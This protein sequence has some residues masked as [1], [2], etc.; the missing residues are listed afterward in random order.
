MRDSIFVV[1][2]LFGR[3]IRL[4]EER[5]IHILQRSELE[6]QLGK[7]EQTL[8]DP[9]VV[10]RSN[11]DPEIFLYYRWYGRTPVGS[12]YLVCIAKLENHHGFVL[13]SFF[14]DKVKVGETIWQR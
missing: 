7:I 9:D 10:K 5:V 6:G 2:D 11:H 8:M 4:S 1:S 3:D 14:T 13:T 12:K